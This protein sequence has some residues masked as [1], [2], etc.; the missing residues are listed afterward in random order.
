MPW[1]MVLMVSLEFLLWGC[2]LSPLSLCPSDFF[3]RFHPGKGRGT[4]AEGPKPSTHPGREVKMRNAFDMP[5]RPPKRPRAPD[6]DMQGSNLLKSP[7]SSDGP[8]EPRRVGS[9]R[10]RHD[11]PKHLSHKKKWAYLSWGLS[12]GGRCPSVVAIPGPSCWEPNPA[13]VLEFDVR[14]A[15]PAPQ[16]VVVVLLPLS[17]PSV[18]AI[19]ATPLSTF[20]SSSPRRPQLQANQLRWLYLPPV[21]DAPPAGV[22]RQGAVSDG[23]QRDMSTP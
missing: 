7:P 14:R 15:P 1:L 10:L 13:G 4:E 12:R 3:L 2:T 16:C 19:Q 5:A 17:L 8:A 11:L 20:R 9:H 21:R 22:P 6:M 18:S 23:T